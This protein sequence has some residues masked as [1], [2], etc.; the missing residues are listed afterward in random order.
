MSKDD[1]M[2]KYER[3]GQNP[4]ESELLE[5]NAEYKPTPPGQTRRQFMAGLFLV[6]LA[7]SNCAIDPGGFYPV[8]IASNI[9]VFAT[10]ALMGIYSFIMGCCTI[11]SFKGHP[12]AVTLFG[13]SKPPRAIWI[14]WCLTGV[15]FIGAGM[16]VT[17]LMTFSAVGCWAASVYVSQRILHIMVGKMRAS[18]P[19][20]REL[21]M[22]EE[23]GFI[24]RRR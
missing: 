5:I 22:L 16:P 6:F 18:R 8:P 20:E 11:A 15:G 17:A 2:D 19:S 23:E 3:M 10:V 1:S 12:A 7:A 13:V 9:L 4:I 21:Q 24:T 14:L